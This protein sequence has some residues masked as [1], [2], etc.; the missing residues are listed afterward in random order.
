[1]GMS[2]WKANL[3]SVL[4]NREPVP[5]L[6]PAQETHERRTVSRFFSV[7]R[8]AFGELKAEIETTDRS[9]EIH[10]GRY[11]HAIETFHEGRLEFSYAVKVRLGS[12]PNVYQRFRDSSFDAQNSVRRY[13]YADIHKIGERRVIVDF[14]RAYRKWLKHRAPVVEPVRVP[15]SPSRCGKVVRFPLLDQL[16]R[17]ISNFLGIPLGRPTYPRRA[18]SIRL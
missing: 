17:H 12:A 14:M 18:P 5:C 11:A 1:M 6:G 2:N 4:L 13:A 3:R 7:V 16:A 9:V 10:V 8:K 15:I